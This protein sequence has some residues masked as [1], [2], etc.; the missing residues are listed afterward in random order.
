MQSNNIASRSESE[1]EEYLKTVAAV[2][3]CYESSE[4]GRVVTPKT[5]K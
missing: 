3:A 4:T 1:G 2:L 5:S